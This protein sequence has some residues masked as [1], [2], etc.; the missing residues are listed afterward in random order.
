MITIFCDFRQFSTKKLAFFSKTNVMI[1]TLHNLALFWVEK[2]QFFCWNFRWK[3]LK[4]HNIGPRS[5]AATQ[6]SLERLDRG[7]PFYSFPPEPIRTRGQSSTFSPGVHF[8]NLLLGKNV[9][10]QTFICTRFMDE[11]SSKSFTQRNHLDTIVYKVKVHSC[12]V[13]L[14]NIGKR[15]RKLETS[16]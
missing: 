12:Y 3:Y 9:F 11:I 1:K 14:R 8:V 10:G 13:Y 2:R 16:I 7:W 4:N 6:Q 15:W 5:T